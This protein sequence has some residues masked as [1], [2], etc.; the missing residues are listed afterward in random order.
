MQRQ[1]YIEMKTQ[2]T[3]LAAHL[4]KCAEHR[5]RVTQCHRI[6]KERTRSY[7]ALKMLSDEY[8]QAWD[9]NAMDAE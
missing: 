4:E 3:E 9:V 6:L 2:R 1:T 5:H 7:E 8:A